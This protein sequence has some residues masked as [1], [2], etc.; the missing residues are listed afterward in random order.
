MT[1]LFGIP[2]ADILTGTLIAFAAV[3]AIVAVFAIRSRVFLRLALRSASRRLGRTALIVAGLMLGTTIITAA[4]S[5]G[6]TMSYTIRSEVLDALGNVD[7]VVSREG[8]ELGATIF[9][10]NLGDIEYI[11]ERFFEDVDDAAAGSEDIDGITP[12]IIEIVGVQDLTSA[13]TE[14][15]VTIFAADPT[16]MEPFGQIRDATSGDSLDLAALGPGEAYLNSEGA[17]QLDASPGDEIAIYAAGGSSPATVKAVVDYKGAGTTDSALL[18]PLSEAQRVLNAEGMIKHILISNHGGDLSGIDLTDA[19]I[20]HL[21]PALTPLGLEADPTKQDSVD[22]ADETGAAFLSIF[23]TFGSFSV[24]AGML[25]IF[26]IFVMLAQERKGEMGVA[27]A[28]G[29]QRGH[30]AQA[31]VFEGVA[32]DLLAALV[33]GVAGVAIAFGMVII[34]SQALGDIAEIRHTI[35]PR[36]IIVAYIIGMLVTFIVV[37]ISAWRVSALNIVRAI[38]DLPDPVRRRGGGRGWI[39]GLIAIVLGALLAFSGADSKTAAPFYLGVSLVIIGSVPVLRRFGVPDRPAYTIPGIILVVYWLLPFDA[40]IADLSMDFTIF[41]LSGIFVVTGATWVVMYNSDVLIVRTTAV[42]S[43][44]RSLAPAIKTAVAYPLTSKFRTGVTLAMFTLVVFT[45]VVMSITITS[46]GD[47]FDDQESFG[48]GYDVRATAVSSNPILDP[49]AAI[50]DAPNLNPDDFESI[51]LQSS[52]SVKARQAGFEDTKELEDYGI[53]GF[54]DTFLTN[55]TYLLA[56]RAEGYDSDRAVWDAIRDNPR[57]AIVSQDAVPRRQNWGF[58][59]GLPDFRLEGFYIEDD[60][61]EPVDV[62]IVDSQ[63]GSNFQ[64]S[65][66]GV[67]SDAGPFFMTGVTTSQT[68]LARSLPSQRIVP[69]TLWVDLGPGVDPEDTAEAMESAFLA[70]GLEANSLADELADAVELNQTFNYIIQGFMSLGLIVGV[71]AIGVI[72]ARSVV[73]RR[74]QIGVL[75]SIGFQKS[76]VQLIFLIESSLVALVGI[77]VGT[78]LGLIVAYDVIDQAAAT[79]SWANLQYTIPFRDLIIIFTLVYLAA[80]LASWFPA[81]QASRVYP[82]EALRYE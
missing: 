64:V 49:A 71:V 17:D 65:I 18:M 12:A 37:T 59:A 11:P 32:Y 15:R 23:I 19:V 27:R 81:R 47:A 9:V 39:L 7:V 38:R 77:F 21:E 14:P 56:T 76:T 78:I 5:T 42:L 69:T 22:L 48:G 20:A 46:F 25:L 2:M 68:T 24:I 61:F 40:F 10:D 80:L 74:Q 28:V 63:T 73:E 55:T 26:L 33:G 29:A 75:R 67:L 50:A 35:V 58:S 3:L 6:D 62:N 41:I 43:R 82:A 60:S 57:L 66:I 30:L 44:L 45:M 36:S 1:E 51:A 4:F 31:F 54:D 16:R 52:I 34:L 13:Q 79:G 53:L 70:N 8:A 72:S